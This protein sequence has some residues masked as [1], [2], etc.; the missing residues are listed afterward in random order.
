MY[1]C[2]ELPLSPFRVP[3]L[4][5]LGLPSSRFGMPLAPFGV[6]LVPCGRPLKS[7]AYT[8]CTQDMLV[9]VW[10]CVIYPK[11]TPTSYRKHLPGHVKGIARSTACMSMDIAVNQQ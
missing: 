3:L 8:C 10:T 6:P 4:G 9:N 2:L 5:A 11:M 7:P 1:M